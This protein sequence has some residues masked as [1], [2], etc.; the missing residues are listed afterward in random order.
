MR[1]ATAGVQT[2]ANPNRAKVNHRR[3][4]REPT[5]PRHKLTSMANANKNNHNNGSKGSF[6]PDY[7]FLF[8][9]TIAG[10]H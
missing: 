7:A 9:G 8:T 5:R 4:R 3:E 2:A 1:N 6:I 10:D